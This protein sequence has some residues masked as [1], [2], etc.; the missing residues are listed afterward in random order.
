MIFPDKEAILFHMI[1]EVRAYMQQ[2]K[3]TTPGDHVIVGVSGGADSVC[4]LFLLHCLK[5]ELGITLSAVHV[6]H[7]LRAEADG[8]AGFVADLCGQWQI[9]CHVEEVDVTA[10]AQEMGLCT[11]EAARRLRYEVYERLCRDEH[12]KIA[13]AHH[14]NDQA[15]TVLFHLFRGSSIRGM[16]G[17]L[18][19]RDCFIRPLLTR[20]REEIEAFLKE[21]QLSFVTDQSN[22]DTTYARNRIRHEILPLA[23]EHICSQSVSHI[24]AMAQNTAMAVDFLDEQV[25]KAYEGLVSAGLGSERGQELR[26]SISQL[27][28]LHPYLQSALIYEMLA[29]VAGRKRDISMAHVDSVLALMD[30][31]SGKG[32]DLIYGIYAGREF[33]QLVFFSKG[34]SGGENEGD[35]KELKKGDL[36]SN[37]SGKIMETCIFSYEKGMII[38]DKTYTKWFDYDKINNCPVV[39]SRESGDYIYCTPTGRKKLKDYLIQEKIPASERDRI[40][41]IADGSHIL[42]VPGYR[43]SSYTK[44]SE[45]TKEILEITVIGGNEDGRQN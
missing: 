9:P 28:N 35:Q 38:P 40:A 14:E 29:C 6:N 18:P 44:I 19:V 30:G 32:I 8:E 4:L 7:R 3:M 24:A 22:F 23:T 5:E 16:T 43:I 25:E 36:Y 39:R 11:E 26:I 33:D 31:Q 41:V 37:I 2:N 17:I 34:K 1:K 27:K 20:S 45:A 21:K 13:L 12:T 15:E 42:W 10:F